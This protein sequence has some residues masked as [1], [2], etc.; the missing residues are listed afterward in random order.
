MTQ[1]EYELGYRNGF[2]DAKAAQSSQAIAL[3]SLLGAALGALRYH[4]E[5][6][7]PIERTKETIKAIERELVE[8][9]VL[10]AQPSQCNNDDELPGMWSHSDT[11]GGETDVYPVQPS[12]AGEPDMFWN[13]ADPEKP[14]SSVDEF[15]NAEICSGMPLEVGDTRTIQCAI[16][17]PNFDVRVTSIDEE[18]SEAEFEII[19][20]INAKGGV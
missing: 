3:R 9:E 13:D 4:T 18:E 1:R 6:T 17:L 14:Y 7:R 10:A 2:A 19:A 12:Q 5:Q 16:R 20:T 15:L 11:E 8:N